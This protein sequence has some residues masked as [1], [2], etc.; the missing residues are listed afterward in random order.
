MIIQLWDILFLI[1]LFF[2]LIMGIRKG[3]LRSLTLLSAHLFSCSLALVFSPTLTGLFNKYLE[4]NLIT[5]FPAFIL[6]Y[7]IPM[8]LLTQLFRV[9]YK[10]N[11]QKNGKLISISGRW[12]G[13]VTGAASGGFLL[14]FSYLDSSLATF[15]SPG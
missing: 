7:L 2:C 14:L 15:D 9:M 3:F 6:I 12:G 4:E 8:I 5:H 13:L 1:I 11:I 10:K